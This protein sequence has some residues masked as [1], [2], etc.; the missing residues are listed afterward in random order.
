MVGVWTRPK[1]ACIRGN[2]GQELSN[3]ATITDC[4]ELCEQVTS[5]E[6]LSVD[7]NPVGKKCHL[8]GKVK[9][10]AGDD[11]TAPCYIEPE[12]WLYSERRD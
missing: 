4:V 12:E 2:N 8:S 10:T 1:M 7:F 11:Y 6:C 9:F 5:F 3:F